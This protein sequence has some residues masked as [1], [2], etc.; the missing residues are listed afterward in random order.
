M[1]KKK[2]KS[3]KDGVEKVEIKQVSQVV[4]LSQATYLLGVL[5]IVFG[6]FIPTIGLILGIVGLVKNR[7]LNSNLSR[8]AK[9]LNTAGIVVSVLVM[10]LFLYLSYQAGGTSIGGLI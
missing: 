7:K 10:V 8:K 6:I 9:M 2:S 4:D 5:S 3:K 1:V